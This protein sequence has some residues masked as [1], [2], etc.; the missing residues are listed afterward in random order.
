MADGLEVLEILKEKHKRRREE[1]KYHILL[2]LQKEGFKTELADSGSY[3]YV[4]GI[5]GKVFTLDPI[6]AKFT[7][8]TD[9]YEGRGLKNLLRQGRR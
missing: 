3:Y 4:T 1:R 9:S 8:L 5:N 7:R 2:A 6:T